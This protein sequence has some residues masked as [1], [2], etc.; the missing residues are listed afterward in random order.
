MWVRCD[1]VMIMRFYDCWAIGWNDNEIM[2]LCFDGNS[3]YL[4]I[5]Y[6][7]QSKFEGIKSFS[8]LSTYVELCRDV[9]SFIKSHPTL[10][11]IF[12]SGTCLDFYKVG[13]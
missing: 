3:L 11:H 10:N 8:L 13:S 7:F 6:G 9:P 2:I 4:D 5:V 1:I 12:I